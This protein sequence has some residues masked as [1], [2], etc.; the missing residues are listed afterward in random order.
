VAL[1]VALVAMAAVAAP[2]FGL[3]A[4]ASA[5][6]VGAQE[7]SK[8]GDVPKLERAVFAGGCFWC[9]QPPFDKT[10]GVVSTRVG[11]TGGTL[12]NPTYEQVSKKGTGH[13]EAIEVWFRPDKISY[14]QLLQ[15]FFRSMDPTDAQGQFADRGSPYRPGIF[16]INEAQ[17]KIAE[18]SKLGLVRSGRFSKP[19][20]VPILGSGVFYPAEKYHQ[21]Y[22]LKDP[23][24]Y[25]GYKW[26]SG[27]AAFLKRVWDSPS[28][29]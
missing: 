22:Y 3:W 20:V 18:A 21:K 15:V 16:Y 23:K 6:G 8:T 4:C 14:A 7:G 19:I 1:V 9:M 10:E 13:R 17:K 27:R 26:S 25:E 2:V 24:R 28:A 5:P 11:Y 29:R 12:P